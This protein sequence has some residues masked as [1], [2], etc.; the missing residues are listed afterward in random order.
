[1]PLP[2]HMSPEIIHGFLQCLGTALISRQDS[3]TCVCFDADNA[4]F[5]LSTARTLWLE[6]ELMRMLTCCRAGFLPRSGMLLRCVHVLRHLLAAC[7]A[8]REVHDPLI[9]PAPSTFACV[10][11]ALVDFPQPRNPLYPV[12]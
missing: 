4:K 9:G 2:S 3:T 10:L 1:M 11:S 5:G 6:L 12:V 7:P 8:T